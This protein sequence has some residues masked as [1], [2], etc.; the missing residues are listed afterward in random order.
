MTTLVF[1]EHHDGA[2]QKGA[3]GVLAKA[4]SLGDADAVI[5]G[6]GAKSLAA[7]AGK[8]GAKKV[9]ACEDAE[10]AQPLILDGTF[11]QAVQGVGHSDLLRDEC[12]DYAQR[13]SRH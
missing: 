4:A 5:V 2:L 3:L 7:Q 9:W 8:Y 6:E 10:V 11:L 12:A 1:L 13:K